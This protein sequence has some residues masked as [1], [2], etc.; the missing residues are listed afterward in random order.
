MEVIW[1]NCTLQ[2]KEKQHDVDAATPT[3]PRAEERHRK[4]EPSRL[5]LRKSTIVVNV[6][7]E[8]RR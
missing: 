6:K 8:K 1:Y 4:K 5:V 7:A 2:K 3:T